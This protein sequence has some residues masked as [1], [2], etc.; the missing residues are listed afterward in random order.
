MWK[1]PEA[2]Y[3]VLQLEKGL[4]HLWGAVITFFK[5]ALATW[6]QF[7]SEFAPG[8]MIADSTESKHQWAWMGPL[9]DPSKGGLGELRGGTRHAPNM[10]IDNHNA[11]VM[12]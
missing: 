1:L 6:D 3:A 9:N 11:R 8:G 5:G 12:Y 2:M 10:T 7:T 4:P